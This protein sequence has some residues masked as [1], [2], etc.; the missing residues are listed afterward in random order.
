MFQRT[1]AGALLI[2]AGTAAGLA[3]KLIRDRRNEMPGEDDDD[4]IR[5]ISITDDEEP[6]EISNEAKELCTVYPYL[7]PSF[8][9]HMLKENADLNERY[10][11][12]T[13]VTITHT[14]SF[15]DE[16]SADEFADIMEPNGYEII[17][18]GNDLQAVRRFFTRDGAI[19][20][21]ILN[22]ANQTEALN[23]VYRNYLAES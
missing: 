1:L 11:E 18:D 4:E 2:A 9:D 14:V 21:D 6:E 20:S 3:Y 16:K 15:A 22:V 12:D 5:F 17:K 13:L 23:G 10:P 8:A 7:D 19:V